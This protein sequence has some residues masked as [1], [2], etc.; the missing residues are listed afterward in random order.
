MINISTKIKVFFFNKFLHFLANVINLLVFFILWLTLRY[1]IF[2]LPNVGKAI[3]SHKE[4]FECFL[5]SIDKLKIIVDATTEIM[6]VEL[7][8]SAN[9]LELQEENIHAYEDKQTIWEA[10][11]IVVLANY[12][13]FTI[14]GGWW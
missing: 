5:Q 9:E 10:L 7:A 2:D 1:A 6:T 8:E 4:F 13:L 14:H 11:Y 3:E 12:I